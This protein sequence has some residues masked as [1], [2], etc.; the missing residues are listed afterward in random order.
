MI[1]DGK[2][3]GGVGD[4]AGEVGHM[5]IKAGGPKCGCGGRGHLEALCSRTAIVREIAKMVKRGAKSEIT[6][7]AGGN[8][9]QA[10]SGDLAKALL[11]GDKVVMKVLDRA[12]KHLALG[13]AS[14][15]NLLNPEM[16]VLGGGVIEALGDPFVERVTELVR[17]QPLRAATADLKIVKSQLGDD[18]GITG[19][20]LLARQIQL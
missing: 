5:T 3:Y 12:S 1:M 13:I 2:L 20:A 16:V 11:R 9:L 15:A 7:I 19:A 18:A 10:T 8:I 4:L 14:V 6:K 17:K